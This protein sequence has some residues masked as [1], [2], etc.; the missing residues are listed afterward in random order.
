VTLKF[1]ADKAAT[2]PNIDPAFREAL[3]QIKPDPDPQDFERC[4]LIVSLR[5]S[6]LKED[7]TALVA[8]AAENSHEIDDHELVVSI[9]AHLSDLNADISGAL[10]KAGEALREAR[11][12]GVSARGPY[13]RVRR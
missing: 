2:G 6:A 12:E 11:Y 8:L 13:Y 7:L 9:D 3:P 1:I 4:A 5:I 10:H